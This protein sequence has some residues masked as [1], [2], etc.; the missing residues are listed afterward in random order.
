MK[1]ILFYALLLVSATFVWSGCQKGNNYP[2][3][4]IASIMPLMDIRLVYQGS[5]VTLDT[6]AML[7]ATSITGVVISDFSGG[8][9]P[10]GLLVI[11]DNRRLA[12]YR[13]IAVNIGA[14]AAKYIPGDSLTIKVEGSILIRVNGILQINNVPTSNIVKNKSGAFVGVTKVT[15][16]Q[17]LNNPSFYESTYVAI[18]KG[19]FDPIPT[20]AD[21]FSGDHL[22]NDGFDNLTLHTETSAVF[23]NTSLPVSA[24]FYGIVFNVTNSTGA[25]VPQLRLRNAADLVVLSNNITPVPFVI[26]GFISDV[27]GG[28][29]NYEYVQFVATQDIDFSVTPYS[30]VFCNNAGAATPL[31]YPVN[32]WASG[33]TSTTIQFKTYKINMVSGTAKKGTYFYVGG[34][35]KNIN[36]SLSTSMTASNWIRNYDYVTKAGEGFGTAFGGILA[37]SGNASGIAVFAGINVTKDSTPIDCEFVSTGGSLYQ[38]SPEAG[39]RVAN[40]DFYDIVDPITLKAQP[41]YRQGTNTLSLTYPATPDIGNFYKLGGVYSARLGK[42]VKA[43]SQTY[44]VLSKTSQLNEIEAEFPTGVTSTQVKD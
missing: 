3:A 27:I 40:S 14:D 4:Q 28:D 23:A 34:L 24:N 29:G 32:G 17:V 9:M 21:K 11:Q 6:K 35:N 43:R 39:Y 2:G 30:V 12:T 31:G 22:V 18:V 36:G 44:V 42:W 26:S 37:N 5:D 33:G 16:T 13:G 10:G 19:G 20:A 41:Y 1:K 15:S 38:A 8:N 25:T 7:G